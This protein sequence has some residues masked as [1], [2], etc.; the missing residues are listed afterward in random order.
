MLPTPSLMYKYLT[1]EGC[2]LFLRLH[3]CKESYNS[4]S[5]QADNHKASGTSLLSKLCCS[6]LNNILVVPF[7]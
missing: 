3:V 1:D 6:S 2:L 5:E 4:S 7:V